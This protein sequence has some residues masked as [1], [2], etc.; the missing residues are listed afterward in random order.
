MSGK[1]HLDCCVCGAGAGRWAQHWNRDTG[2]GICGQCAAEQAAIETP[3]RMQELYGTPGVNYAR[4]QVQH[5]GRW[6]NVLAVCRD[7][8]A[9]RARAN[10]FMERTPGASL[11]C[12][13]DGEAYIAHEDD[14]GSP[15]HFNEAQAK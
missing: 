3:E 10:A 9:G 4:M 15:H 7:T 8:E 2:Y 14:K 5:F 13:I 6:F 1:T 12:V 11:L